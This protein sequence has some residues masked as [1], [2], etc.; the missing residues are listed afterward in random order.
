MPR[1]RTGLRLR[2]D[3]PALRVTFEDRRQ[4][5]EADLG[6]DMATLKAAAVK[7]AARLTIIVEG[8]G[9]DLLSRGVLSPKGSQRAALSAY[10]MTLDRLHRMMTL[11]GLERRQKPAAQRIEDY[12]G[13]AE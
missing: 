9:E 2:D 3:H 1:L 6:A 12:I 4:A 5:I 8:L 10:M 11:L 13:S 7:E